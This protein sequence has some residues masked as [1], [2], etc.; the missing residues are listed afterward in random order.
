MP[1]EVRVFSQLTRFLA[2][3]GWGFSRAIQ[4]DGVRAHPTG[5]AQSVPSLC[6][7]MLVQGFLVTNTRTQTTWELPSDRAPT[8]LQMPHS[9]ESAFQRGHFRACLSPKASVVSTLL[10]CAKFSSKSHFHQLQSPSNSPEHQNEWWE[11]G[12]SLRPLAE[13]T[14][15]CKLPKARVYSQKKIS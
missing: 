7:H 12:T 11:V 10:M 9:T 5:D 8:H 13:P 4:H 6:C 14:V 1:V 2:L 15:D 3:G